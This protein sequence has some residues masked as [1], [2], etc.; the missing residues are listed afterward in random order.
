MLAINNLVGWKEN[1]LL[2]NNTLKIK[3]KLSMDKP[4]DLTDSFKV[5]FYSSKPHNPMLS[6]LKNLILVKY[7]N[8]FATMLI[9]NHVDF[10]VF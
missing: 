7:G 2:I 10:L 9:N 3:F 5:A 6:F 1:L 8:F 4:Y